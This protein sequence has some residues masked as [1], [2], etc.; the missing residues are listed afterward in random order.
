MVTTDSVVRDAYVVEG[1]R[2]KERPKLRIRVTKRGGRQHLT[3]LRKSVICL[4]SFLSDKFL[5]NEF[6]KSCD[7]PVFLLSDTPII[8][9]L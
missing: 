6:Y 3:G 2:A 5:K 7:Y 8:C 1:D 4:L 9:Y